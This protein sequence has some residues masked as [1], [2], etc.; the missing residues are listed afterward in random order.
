MT[1]EELIKAQEALHEEI[2]HIAEEE[3]LV[4]KDLCP[5]YDG[6]ANIEDYL[7]S[8][9]K[10]MWLLKEPYDDFDEAGNPTGGGWIMSEDGLNHPEAWKQRSYQ[11]MTYITYGYRHNSYWGDLPAIRNNKSMLNELKSVAYINISK[12]PGHKNT[13][14]FEAASYYSLWKEIIK[15]QITVYNPDVII[16]GGTMKFFEPD[17]DKTLLTKLESIGTDDTFC[18]IFKYNKRWLISAKH[19]ARFS[20]VYVDGVIDS[21]KFV[22]QQKNIC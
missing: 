14:D 2:Q 5:I 21:L 12:M 20:E 3:G 18:N 9:L 11:G 19:P 16:F 8:T 7:H 22:E 6:V 1:T 15:T 13:S 4:S 17:L 10:I